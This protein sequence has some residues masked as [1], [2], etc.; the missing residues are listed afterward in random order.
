[1]GRRNS[2]ARSIIYT[3]SMSIPTTRIILR[4]VDAPRH[5]KTMR[6]RYYDPSV[7]KLRA[8]ADPFLGI[9]GTIG[10]AY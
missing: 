6:Q 8:W 4:M 2:N 3:R 5:I 9:Y 7:G 1:M 10:V